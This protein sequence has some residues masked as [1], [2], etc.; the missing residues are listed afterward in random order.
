[1]RIMALFTASLIACGT[2]VACFTASKPDFDSIPDHAVNLKLPDQLSDHA[3]LQRGP[4][5][6]V[7]GKA[8]PNA[9]VKVYLGDRSATCKADAGGNWVAQLDLSKIKE[10]PFKFYV[11]S[12]DEKIT[13]NDFLVGEVFLAGG[14]SNMEKRVGPWTGQHPVYD[15]EKICRESSKYNRIRMANIEHRMSPVKLEDISGK[16][17]LPNEK[18]T[19]VF[20][21]AAWF[22]AVEFQKHM[23]VPV[24]IINN[25]HGGSKMQVWTSREALIAAGEDP[26]EEFRGK[27]STQ[28][29]NAE[30][31]PLRHAT[32]K[33]V[34]WYQG[35]QNGWESEKF[36]KLYSILINDWRDLYKRKDLPFI[37]VQLP[38]F[39]MPTAEAEEPADENYWAR[40]REAQRKSSL[41]IPNN[42]MVVTTDTG[43][44]KDVHT[45]DKKPIGERLAWMTLNKL[46][47]KDLPADYPVFK[48]AELNGSKV[49]V[50]FDKVGDGLMTRPVKTK[51]VYNATTPDVDYKRNS[52]NADIENFAIQDQSG[53]WFWADEASII[54]KDKVSVSCRA[55]AKPVRIRYNLTSFALGNL[56]GKNNLPATQF[57]EDVE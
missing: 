51:I 57:E 55:V 24:G 12:G 53:K 50:T 5:T 30:V 21:A 16:W 23:D 6:N 47:G 28:L 26:N 1:M 13:R 39:R 44:I 54:A 40:T 7:W 14:Q 15:Y 22:F 49:I 10:G 29:Y 52:P 45:R 48:K 38:S 43:E 3:V 46:Y 19:A 34:L 18:S 36:E 35:E 11:I 8:L 42:Y 20:S 9:E 41:S 4:A 32:F 2:L 27:V 25:S 17:E 33:A 37:F 31:W 56:Y